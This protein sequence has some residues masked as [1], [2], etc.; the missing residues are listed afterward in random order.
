[1]VSL[2]QIKF[3]VRLASVGSL[4]LAPI[5]PLHFLAAAAAPVSGAEKGPGTLV[6]DQIFFCT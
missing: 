2:Q 3:T 5:R 1:M 4:R 6:L